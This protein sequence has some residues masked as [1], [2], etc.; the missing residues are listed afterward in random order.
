[1][2]QVL[3]HHR[4]SIKALVKFQLEL[5]DAS[6]LPPDLQVHV[7]EIVCAVGRIAQLVNANAADQTSPRLPEFT[8]LEEAFG[9]L[10]IAVLVAAGKTNNTVISTAFVKHH[11]NLTT[12]RN[13][14]QAD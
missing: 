1:M 14:N 6:A 3:E 7:G 2:N 8:R 9:D 13:E 4:D 12:P 5:S 11:Y 10:L